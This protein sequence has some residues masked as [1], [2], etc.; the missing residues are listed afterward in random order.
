MFVTVRTTRARALARFIVP[1]L[2]L[3]GTPNRVWAAPPE[4]PGSS[5]IPSAP[6]T[7]TPTRPAPQPTSDDDDRDDD[8]AEDT[9][10]PRLARILRTEPG[11]EE[12][13]EATQRYLELTPKRLTKIRR[14]ARTRALLPLFA[15]GGRINT[16]DYEA[17]RDQ[18]PQ[19]FHTDEEHRT[20]DLAAN[21]GVL[22]DLRDLAFTAA[23][24][25]VYSVVEQRRRILTE[26]SRVYLA[27]RLLQIDLHTEEVDLRTRL[28]LQA[29]IAEYT[30]LLDAVT[31]GWFTERLQATG[32]APA[33]SSVDQPY[34]RFPAS[35]IRLDPEAASADAS[36][37]APAPVGPVRASAESKVN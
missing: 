34:I 21:V 17:D 35:T 28:R 16:V 9:L 19:N 4:A 20:N 18:L 37:A 29:R 36:K 13:L 22:W 27:R 32:N 7:D 24:L 2:A 11:P 14:R 5:L 33:L 10:S 31:G 15:V 1:W 25:D 6:A 3:Q 23:E 12:V 26:V 30:A 8:D